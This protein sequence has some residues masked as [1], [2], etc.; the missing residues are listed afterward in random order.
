[1]V[2]WLYWFVGKVKFYIFPHPGLTDLLMKPYMNLWGDS[3]VVAYDYNIDSIVV[4][5]KPTWTF[6]IYT[7]TNQSAGKTHIDEMKR[8]AD[9][10][11]GLNS[12]INRYKPSYFSKK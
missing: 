5:F 7:Y 8:L 10:W 4:Q 6:T 12:Y 1:M 3:N 2:K 9:A 11:H